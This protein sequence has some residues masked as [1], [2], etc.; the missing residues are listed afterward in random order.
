MDPISDG[1]LET[2]EIEEIAGL[3]DS[4]INIDGMVELMLAAY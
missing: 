2:E 4:D 1:K 3:V